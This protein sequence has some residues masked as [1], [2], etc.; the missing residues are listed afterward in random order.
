[1]LTTKKQENTN[2]EQGR[3]AQVD[4]HKQKPND[5]ENE[6]N[7]VNAHTESFG[8]GGKTGLAPGGRAAQK[9]KKFKIQILNGNSCPTV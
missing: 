7:D 2:N 3:D 8:A 9:Q 4:N 6:T 1:M 5:N